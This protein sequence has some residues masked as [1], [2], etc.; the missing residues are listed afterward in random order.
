V[1]RCFAVVAIALAVGVAGAG[2]AVPPQLVGKWTRTITQADVTHAR[3]N[4]ITA[5]S[6]WTLIIRKSGVAFVGGSAGQFSGNVVPAGS[7]K[8]H[9]N[10]GTACPNVYTWKSGKTLTFTKV[11][12]CEPDRIAVFNGVWKRAG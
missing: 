4:G 7:G 3:A 12:D 8:V 11:K 9:V 6:E 5:G 1:R 2:A 10:L